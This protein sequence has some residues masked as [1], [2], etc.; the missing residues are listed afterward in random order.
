MFLLQREIAAI[1]S[2][3]VNLRQMSS[4]ITDDETDVPLI[5]LISH[6]CA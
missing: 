1:I 2:E 4:I 5:P 3:R 6:R